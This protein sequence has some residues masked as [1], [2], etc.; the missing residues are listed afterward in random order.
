MVNFTMFKHRTKQRLAK[1]P[2]GST[3]VAVLTFRCLSRH[4]LRGRGE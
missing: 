1:R 3:R 4:R 2:F